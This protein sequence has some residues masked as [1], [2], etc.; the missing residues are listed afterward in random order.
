MWV[1]GVILAALLMLLGLVVLALGAWLRADEARKGLLGVHK[2]LAAIEQ[3]LGIA[4]P[5]PARP[6]AVEAPAR[7]VPGASL[8]EKIALVWFARIGAGI[9]LVGALFFLLAPGGISGS[10]RVAAGVLFG[11][12]ALG[13]AEANRR[14]ARPLFNQVVLGM[15]VAVLLFTAF[16]S[17]RLY[18]FAPA[19]VAFGAV[20]VAAALG[21]FL[22]RR[23]RAEIALFLAVAG[24][25]LAPVLLW[26]DAPPWGLLAWW[27]AFPLAAAAVAVRGIFPW[28]L[29]L[30]LLGSAGLAL[31]WALRAWD[32]GP[33]GTFH[34]LPARLAP[35][36]FAALFAAG[37]SLAHRTARAPGRERL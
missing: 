36:A 23:H 11:A 28:S 33:G 24:G 19:G 2:R 1:V 22:A 27:L 25:L 32:L 5:Q 35:L 7:A 15:G 4:R 34:P 9:L 12:G 29:W 14:R 26:R 31:G 20:V 6:K 17:H 10:A 37:W 30:S 13:F 21:A 16:V 18:G 3:H 8:E